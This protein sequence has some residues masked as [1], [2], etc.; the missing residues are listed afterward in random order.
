MITSEAELRAACEREFPRAVNDLADLVAI[1]SVSSLPE[2]AADV[3]RSA[4]AIA[5]LLRDAGC[6]AVEVVTASGGGLPA[7]IG[8]WPAPEG[9]PTVCLYAHHDVQPTGDVT[10]W[11]GG[12]PF[13]AVRR[14]QRMFG[15]GCG[16]DKGGFIAHLI[17]LRA[18]DGRP[19]VGVTVFVEGEEE[20]GSPSMAALLREHRAELTADAY[21]ICDG[22]NWEAGI[23]TF[24]G[25]LR[26]MAE[27][28]VTV[29]TSDRALH[30]GM[31]GGAIPD[32]LTLL[33]VLVS[34]IF[35]DRGDVIVPG[36]GGEP[37]PDL[38]YPIERLRA[39]T[40][41]LDGV[42]LIGTGSVVERL[43][44]K[45]AVALLAVDA[46]S[47]ALAS[48]TL[49]PATRAKLGIRVPPGTDAVAAQRALADFLVAQAPFGAV[50]EVKLGPAGQPWRA[51]LDSAIAQVA[52]DAARDAFGVDPV[53]IGQGGSIPLAA[54]LEREFG[55]PVLVTAVLD[56]TSAMHAANESV[57]LDDV[58]RAGLTEALWLARLGS[59][60]PGNNA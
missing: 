52:V 24:T 51:S 38:D 12:E 11:E 23:P 56:P 2:H 34:R 16:D 43:W 32:S 36:L 35:D 39:E 15:R 10:L 27:L 20:I 57:D 7:V 55:A 31:F 59:N 42:E 53:T 22:G 46:P 41:L 33:S 1:A 28:E 54:E 4:E 49:Y 13:R 50:V 40:G 6:P 48:N 14:G 26:G 37:A 60:Q 21:L 5:A 47:V 19:P 30:S 18:F 58:L 45:P 29:R 8:R 9:Q 44:T 3:A 17:A 25:T